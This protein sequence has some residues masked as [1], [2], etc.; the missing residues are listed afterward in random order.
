[1]GFAVVAAGLV[2]FSLGGGV[3]AKLFLQAREEDLEQALQ[4]QLNDVFTTEGYERVKNNL[5]N[6]FASLPKGPDGGL[7]PPTVRYAL[8]RYFKQQ[9]GWHINSL[10]HGAKPNG[11]LTNALQTPWTPARIQLVMEKLLKGHG[12]DLENLAA[13]AATVV[14]LVNE[15][16]A[17]RLHEAFDALD[18]SANDVLSDDDSDDASR[19]YILSLLSDDQYRFWDRS[20]WQ[21]AER[22]CAVNY[23]QWGPTLMWATDL[24]HAHDHFHQS[25]RNPFVKHDNTFEDITG[26]MIEFGQQFGQLQMAECSGMKEYLM[27]FESGGTGR[28]PL[29]K[30]YAASSWEFHFAENIEYLRHTHVLDE[31]NPSRPMVIIP[32]YINGKSNCLKASAFYSIC[33]PDECERLTE[34]VERRI[35]APSAFPALIAEVVSG[36]DSDTVVA[37]RNLSSSLLA[38]LDDVAKSNEG[39]VPLHGRL[40]AQWMHHAFPRECSFPQIAEHDAL[41]PEDWRQTMQINTVLI[42]DAEL[43]GHLTNDLNAEEES[44]SLTLPWI[45]EEKL[46]AGH[47]RARNQQRSGLS[48][49]TRFTVAIAGMASLV[50]AMLK[51]SPKGEPCE[52]KFARYQV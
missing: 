12:V 1:M 23:P 13:L 5:R 29:S 48:T 30:F 24:S 38:R 51:M 49:G 52:S 47:Q 16:V 31:S 44:Y 33:C 34:Q 43:E 28:V 25:R 18:I 9:Y 6:M 14:D 27:S 26:F 50:A 41:L 40:F 32:N 36:L 21:E 42:S 11:T 22:D 4:S 37:P 19:A 2:A 20:S 15:E 3:H 46:I 35:Q 8:Q 39:R 17:G 45:H 10:G 7:E